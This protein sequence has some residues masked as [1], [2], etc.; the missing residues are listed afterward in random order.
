LIENIIFWDK[1]KNQRN[2]D[3][4]KNSDPSERTPP[5]ETH[6]ANQPKENIG[7]RRGYEILPDNNVRFGVKIINNS[8]SAISDAEVI[9]DYPE[10]LFELHGHKTRKLGTIPPT[11]MRTA[12]FIMKPRGCIHKENV[13][14]TIIYKD[15]QWKKHVLDMRPKEMHCII[16]FLK[17]KPLTEAEYIHMAAGSDFVQEGI[18]FKGVSVQDFAKFM[19]E[20]RRY[21]QYKVKEYNL[22]GKKVIYL[23]GESIGEK[24][25]Y[26]LT[27]VLQ[28]Y[29]GLTQVVLKANSDK[30][31]GL[32]GFMNEMVD[33]IN[34]FV[35]SIQNAREIGIIENNHVINIIDSVVMRTSI[36]MGDG[37]KVQVNI[38]ESVVQ[39]TDF[40]ENINNKILKSSKSKKDE[41]V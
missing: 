19:D 15:Y 13:S 41:E 34:H 27:V 28:D 14:A 17:E 25:Y 7:I 9:L 30:K 5:N 6:L 1:R 40:G 39:R 33:S 16:P 24:T 21:K 8:E 23:S 11:V 29:Q 3:E 4:L 2:S 37:G 18:T 10:T 31:Y 38:R 22:E 35:G 12:E 36:N 20:N 26:L 32:N